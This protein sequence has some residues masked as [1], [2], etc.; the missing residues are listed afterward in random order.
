VK[1][2][3]DRRASIID[4]GPGIWSRPSKQLGLAPNHCLGPRRD[5]TNAYTEASWR[6]H[7]AVEIKRTAR[8]AFRPA[9]GAGPFVPN[10]ATVSPRRGL[11]APTNC[12]DK[13]GAISDFESPARR[14]SRR[15]ERPFAGRCEPEPGA[16]F[17]LPWRQGAA[18]SNQSA[19]ISRLSRAALRLEEN[20]GISSFD[21][22]GCSRF[23]V[24]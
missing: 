24:S 12:N 8:L 21:W 14:D 16:S 22:W 10:M 23:A 3:S 2:G 13:A 11:R 7:Y 6:H 20:K 9:C 19:S 1:L 18:G 5:R 17:R 4:T 15:R